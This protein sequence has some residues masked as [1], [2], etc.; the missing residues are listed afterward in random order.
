LTLIGVTDEWSVRDLLAH[1][2]WWQQRVLARMRG[3]PA[4]FQQEAGESDEAF[5]QR[6]NAAAVAAMRHEPADK[7]LRDFRASHQQM[8]QT[9]AALTD[10][11]LADENLINSIIGNTYG[12]YAEH[13][14][15]LRAFVGRQ[16]H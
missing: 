14:T 8:V 9:A 5:W 10:A 7:V 13:M 6:V 15:A 1:L 2:T 4:S 16:Q 12:H 3:E 11:Q